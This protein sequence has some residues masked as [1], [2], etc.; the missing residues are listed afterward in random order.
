MS[1]LFKTGLVSL[2]KN[3]GLSQT[4]P[5]LPRG[6]KNVEAE[7]RIFGHC[8]GE[9]EDFLKSCFKKRVTCVKN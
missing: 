4:P 1:A 2:S 9:T 5:P 8:L 6:K 7:P 3:N